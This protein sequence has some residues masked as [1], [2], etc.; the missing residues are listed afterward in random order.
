MSFKIKK[1]NIHST[2]SSLFSWNIYSKT[3]K[4]MKIF[5]HIQMNK[6]KNSQNLQVSNKIIQ[7]VNY[8]HYKFKIIRKNL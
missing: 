2:E 8:I 3:T 6:N 5:T 4:K 7:K 1:N